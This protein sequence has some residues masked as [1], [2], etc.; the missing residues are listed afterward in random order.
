[1]LAMLAM[2]LPSPAS[3]R[4]HCSNLVASL[5]RGSSAWEYDSLNWDFPWN[6]SN[7][8]TLNQSH[9]WSLWHL[10]CLA[11]CRNVTGSDLA[12]PKWQADTTKAWKTLKSIKVRHLFMGILRKA[13][14]IIR[15]HWVLPKSGQLKTNHL[16]AYQTPLFSIGCFLL[17][18]G[19]TLV[20]FL[21]FPVHVVSLY[22]LRRAYQ[23]PLSPLLFPCTFSIVVSCW[24]WAI[25]S[26]CCKF[27]SISLSL[28]LYMIYCTF[29]SLYVYIYIY[30]CVCVWYNII[31]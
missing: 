24:R 8:L 23:T 11:R 4:Q 20:H 10:F 6:H 30:M 7:I 12:M 21:C 27:C 16:G 26:S 5:I 29:K 15:M 14:K 17:K 19:D 13:S 1:M 31:I 18:V 2:P 3:T 22:I 25:L 9:S 28:Y